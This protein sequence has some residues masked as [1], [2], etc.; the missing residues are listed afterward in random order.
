ME[1]Y[2]S[3][4]ELHLAERIYRV[5]GI[6]AAAALLDAAAYLWGI[7]RLAGEFM[8]F[9]EL[10]ESGP[11]EGWLLG[12]SPFYAVFCA[13][14]VAA[15]AVVISRGARY[16]VPSGTILR[17]RISERA[18]FLIRIPAGMACMAVYYLSQAL[19]MLCLSVLYIRANGGAAGPQAMMIDFYRSPFLHGLVPLE[20]TSLWVRNIIFIA[21]IAAFGAV[22]GLSA[23][24]SNKQFE[25]VIGAWIGVI[26]AMRFRS[27]LDASAGMVLAAGMFIVTAGLIVYGLMNA[28]DGKGGR[29]E[30]D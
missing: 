22:A 6:S 7:R 9:S 15:S 29:A 4:F 21:L 26:L 12:L 10:V 16:S 17:L 23:N 3:V 25:P 2:L 13:G 8:Q 14:F 27:E 5:L 28:Q 11:G 20:Y 19:V 30:N 24:T 1:K 18:V